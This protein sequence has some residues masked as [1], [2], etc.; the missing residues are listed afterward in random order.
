MTKTVC[1]IC[2]KEMP[3]AKIVNTIEDLNFCVS[4]HGKRWDICTEC[5]ESLNKWMTI[6]TT[7]SE[8][9][10]VKESDV[11]PT[12]IVLCKDCKYSR[13]AKQGSSDDLYI[14]S[15]HEEYYDKNFG[16]LWRG[17]DYCSRGKRRKTVDL[18]V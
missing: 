12:A 2:G 18:E 7:E 9:M 17:D 8:D 14:C 11:H 5:Q 4:S 3:T 1:D 15:F 10:A 16:M 13:P 6:R